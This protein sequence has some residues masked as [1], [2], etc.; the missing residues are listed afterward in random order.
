V[1]TTLDP[2][3]RAVDAWLKKH[4]FS[5]AHH[6]RLELVTALVALRC[7]ADHAKCA[8]DAHGSMG[9]CAGTGTRQVARDRQM[10]ALNDG[11]GECGICGRGAK[12]DDQ[13]NLAAHEARLRTFSVQMGGAARPDLEK[14]RELCRGWSHDKAVSCDVCQPIAEALAAARAEGAEATPIAEQ[15][16]N[17]RAACERAETDAREWERRHK[18]QREEIANLRAGKPWPES[19]DDAET[20]AAT[21]DFRRDRDTAISRAEQAEARLATVEGALRHTIDS[22]YHGDCAECRAARSALV[23]P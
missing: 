13:G 6:V 14:A 1:T 22:V 12:L 2:E 3:Q 10:L 23:K 15:V 9:T 7:A 19:A 11:Y 5:V 17:L 21:A 16:A 8:H 18:M 20:R 4:G